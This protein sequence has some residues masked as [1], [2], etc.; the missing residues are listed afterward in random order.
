MTLIPE[1]DEK[2]A[3]GERLLERFDVPLPED[4]GAQEALSASLQECAQEAAFTVNA[5][6]FQ[7]AKGTDEPTPLGHMDA[8]Q[9]GIP[10]GRTGVG[11]KRASPTR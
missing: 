4:I 2:I 7:V 1:L 11:R 5:L 9:T 6:S 8:T 3:A 10:D